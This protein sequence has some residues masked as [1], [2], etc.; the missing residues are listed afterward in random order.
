MKE[1]IIQLIEDFPSISGLVLILL[2]LLLLLYQIGKKNTFNMDD[3]NEISWKFLV[4]VWAVII[5]FIFGGLII[6]LNSLK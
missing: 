2:G 4:N 5:I 6:L 3:Y 1:K